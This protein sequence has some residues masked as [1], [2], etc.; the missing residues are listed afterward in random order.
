MSNNETIL[1][2]KNL[3]KSFGVT[4]ANI[5]INLELKKG[6]IRGL[7][8]E[9]GSGKSTLLS[10]IA[11]LYSSDSGE[12]FKD[13]APY[14][15]K[16]PLDANANKIAMVV[17]ELG[18]VGNLP[19]GLNI[20]LGRTKQF[21]NFG[22]VNLKKVYEASNEELRKWGLPTIQ[23]HKL[24]GEMSV[25]SRKMVELARALS[26][27]P[28]IL[29]LD[30][31]TQA[32]SH[33]NRIVLYQL[34]KK[35][36]ELGRSIILITHDLE[37]MIQIT[38]SISILRDGSLIATEDC[39]KLS[40]DMLKSKMVGRELEGEYYRSDMEEIYD[41]EIILSVQ[42]ISTESGLQDISFEIHKGEI[43]GFC[44]LSDSGIHEVGKAV[45]GV[46]KIRSGTIKL[47]PDNTEIK[48]SEQALSHRMA[49]VPK[50]RDGEAL[51][52][53]CPI[54]H[55]FCLAS[56]ENIKGKFGYLS[57]RKM[58]KI[59]NDAKEQFQVKCTSIDQPMSG[60][61]GGNK[62]KINLGRWLIKDLQVLIVDC[63]TR[64]VD[65]G[66]KAYI[67]ECLKIA[68]KNGLAVLLITDE[69][70]E[71]M[72]MADNII[73]MKTGSIKKTIKRSSRFSEEEIIEV[74]I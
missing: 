66:V 42:N 8:G 36:K 63:P 47:I 74:M 11:G 65:V 70:P 31:V 24:A 62:Q 33:D 56:I 54:L 73:I 17:Q 22:V 43:L 59:A 7:A 20:F 26:T 52:M 44:G 37:E 15:P 41:E 57:G 38:D 27:D 53:H 12:M 67:Y 45:Y 50:D 64:G 25:E 4:R 30:E 9:N 60:L 14:Q 40:V 2:I 39:S 72:G 10:Q 13:G 23:F 21:T 55:N 51:M 68:K 3:S 6:E 34:I 35:F 29:I 71:A 16:S 61:S 19:A 48:N 5:N 46:E 49:Y 1:Q 58:K 28:D 32:L 18:L 69:L